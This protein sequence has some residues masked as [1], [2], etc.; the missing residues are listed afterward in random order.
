VPTGVRGIFVLPPLRIW[1][2]DPFGLFAWAGPVQRPAAVV[3]H[4]RAVEVDRHLLPPPAPNEGGDE[5]LEPSPLPTTR[6][7]TGEMAGLRPY[8]AGDRLSRVH[9]P[10]LAGDG[11]ITVRHFIPDGETV[12]RIVVDDRAGAH[13]RHSF[14]LAL[15]VT[16]ALVAR[17][18][19]EGRA[20]D[21]MTLSGERVRVEPTPTG[22][23][24]IL[25]LLAS[26]HPRRLHDRAAAGT[27]GPAPW[28]AEE[29]FG[30][31]TVV[32]TETGAPSLPAVITASGRIVAV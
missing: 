9:W 7:G 32:T 22:T 16:A 8:R 11:D 21:L 17:S 20:V 25:P 4:P 19:A 5:A 14:D 26:L 30:R 24:G 31:C 10:S 2:G 3:V 23:A 15:A 12:V 18:T 29:G 6:E 1:V 13:R 28:E 27:D